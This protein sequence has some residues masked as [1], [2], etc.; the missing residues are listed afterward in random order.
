MLYVYEK[1]TDENPSPGKVIPRHLRMLPVLISSLGLGLVASVAWPMVSYNL[2]SF[3]NQQNDTSN[4]LSPAVYESFANETLTPDEPTVLADVDYTKASNWFTFSPTETPAPGSEIQA[5]PTQAGSQ[6]IDVN[7][8]VTAELPKETVTDH[9]SLTIPA[10]GI[11]DA[12]VSTVSD[13]LN[14][15]L[16]Q[17]RETALPGEFGQPIV[18]G[19][20]TLPQFFNPKNYLAIFATLPTIKVGS[21]IIINFN[22]V[23]YTYRISR[24]YEVKPTDTW[25]LRQDYSKKSFKLIT[26]VPPGTTLRRLIIEADLIPS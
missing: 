22:G 23:E 18:F 11:K 24:M 4:L 26:C 20:S 6:F 25:V 19:H 5:E 16:V 1:A 2:T 8:P 21:D 13:D 10:L 14:K 9:Y 7:R 3:L 12:N 17:F 15:H